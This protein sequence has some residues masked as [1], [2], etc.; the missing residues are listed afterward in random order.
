MALYMMDSISIP[1]SSRTT[2]SGLISVH[3]SHMV[4]MPLEFICRPRQKRCD[5]ARTNYFNEADDP[6]DGE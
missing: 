3:Q 6:S 1:L 4:G 2:G 5:C